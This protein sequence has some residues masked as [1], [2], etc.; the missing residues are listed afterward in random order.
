M[1]V[2]IL[3]DDNKRNFENKLNKS[4]A[5]ISNEF[6]IVDIKYSV[7][8]TGTFHRLEYSAMVIYINKEEN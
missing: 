1:Q 4:L 6:Q 7:V 3:T 8:V 5:E 2:F